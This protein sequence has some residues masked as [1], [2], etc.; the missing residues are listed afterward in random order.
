MTIGLDTSR[1]EPSFGASAS[2][3][4]S[5]DKAEAAGRPEHGGSARRPCQA[6]GREREREESSICMEGEEG[7]GS[8]G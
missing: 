1:A 6:A 8:H 7:E 4:T 5:G 3:S 2:A